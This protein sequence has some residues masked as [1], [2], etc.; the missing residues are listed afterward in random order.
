MTAPPV[1][2][3]DATRAP[4]QIPQLG[5]ATQTVQA[6]RASRAQPVWSSWRYLA[7]AS[8]VVVAYYVVPRTGLLPAWVP[9]IVLY[10]G[11]GLSSVVAIVAGTRRFRPAPALAWYLF[12]AGLAS[13]ATADIIFYTLQDI[14]GL[15]V[16]P[17]AA[18]V[19]YL[20]SY[21]FMMAGILLLIRA[22]SPGTDRPS[23]IDALVITAGV[24]LASW[25]FLMVP[26]ARDPTLSLPARLVSM[27]YPLMDVLLLATVVRLA[28]GGGTRPPA[29]HL[30]L[31]S[32]LALLCTDA[33]YSVIQLSGGY[34]TGSPID[35]GWMAWYACWGAAALHPSMPR[36]SEAVT[37]SEVKL[38]RGRLC[39]LAAASLMAPAVLAAEWLGHQPIEAPAIAVASVLLSLL[40]LVRL[41]G[42]AGQVAGQAEERKRLLDRTVQAAE[43]ERARIA[44]NLHDGPI[45]RLTGLGY[46][47]ALARLHV[48]RGETADSSRI[49][50]GL[51]GEIGVEVKALRQLMIELRPPVLDELGLPAALSDCAAEF[52][53]RSGVRCAVRST[54]RIR[55]PRP[56]ETVL[57]WV[58]QEALTNV[59][60]HACATRAS[61]LLAVENGMAELQVSDDGVGFDVGRTQRHGGQEHF[62][63]AGMRQ[64]VEMAGGTWEVQSHLGRGTTVTAT[65]PLR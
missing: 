17:S 15:N 43:E 5:T 10:N 62:G 29:F 24:G 48:E 26:F 56:L 16:F 44:A 13:F 52:E 63:L 3:A 12:A 2:R 19:F 36:L 35:V 54:A 30:L 22:R 64:R 61:V 8:L 41:S 49:L 27:S 18:D 45:Q 42:L 58:A 59:R 38:G 21:P 32:V 31:V 47:T 6:T 11:L 33:F 65:L 55:L 1:E 25:T 50:E 23:L 37:R 51:E 4:A 39:L 57:Y 7:V 20:A 28:V 53:R 34:H 9:K 46:A 60:K 40:V 14:L